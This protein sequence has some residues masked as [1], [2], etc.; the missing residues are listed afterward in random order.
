MKFLKTLLFLFVL[1]L[2]SIKAPSVAAQ[3]TNMMPF[4]P[5]DT[6][7]ILGQE[8][9]YSVMFRGNGDAMVTMRATFTNEEE[10]PINILSF[11]I[12]RVEPRRVSAFQIIR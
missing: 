8:H 4:R 1:L 9:A 11:R 3:E 5:P 2:F 7:P 10:G 12:P 6:T